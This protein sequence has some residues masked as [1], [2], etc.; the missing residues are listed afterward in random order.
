MNIIIVG[1]GKVGQKLAEQLSIENDHNITVVD[2]NHQAVQDTIDQFDILGV[3]GSGESLETLTEAGLLDADLLIAVTGSDELNLITCLIAKKAGNCQ[4]IARVRNP[5]YSKELRLFQ[6]DLGLAMIINPEFTAA[7]EIARTLR[8]PSAIKIDTFAN[9]RIEILKFRISEDSVLNNLT[10]MEIPS[11]LNCD[12]LVCGVERDSSAFIPRGN[13][14]LKAKDIVSVV[15]SPKNSA[16]FFKKIGVKTNRVKNTTIAGGG[17]TAFYLAASLLQS[18]IDVKI[19]EKNPKR[20]EELTLLLPNA[21]I[22]N[23]DATDNRAL[24]EEDIE[25]AEAF[26]ALTNMD[27][28]NILLSLFV[29]SVSKAK[30][31]TK[32]SK[33]SYDNVISQ[34]GLDT[35]IYPK[36]ITAEYILKFVRALKN[37]IG[38]NVE[39]MHRI[40]DGKA[41]ALEFNIRENS[42][43][44]GTAIENLSI[45][46]DCLIACINRNGQIITPRGKNVILPGDTVIIVTTQTGFKDISDILETRKK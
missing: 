9:G 40:L 38:S 13:F 36:N 37:S 6:E 33:L 2:K 14:V 42:P 23:A 39:T 29:K 34:L 15:A 21:T 27:E 5:V 19:I 12:I 18:G 25:N 28:E 46:K 8:F 45:R 11:K 22:I 16:H 41:E 32:I 1:C 24:L 35:I 3:A 7:E 10:V 43:V 4:T 30:L 31:V 20:C 44:L 17:E 26:V